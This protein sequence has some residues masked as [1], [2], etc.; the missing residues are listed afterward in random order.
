MKGRRKGSIT[1]FLAIALPVILVLGFKLYDYL[2]LRQ[3]EG[4]ALKITYAV[5]EAELGRY[6][7]YFRDNYYVF[8]CF[9]SNQ[10][11]QFVLDYL[12]LNK[13]RGEDFKATGTYKSLS[14]PVN[15]RKAVLNAAPVF[16]S[17]NIIQ[18][19]KEK[20]GHIKTNQRIKA[21]LDEYEII[22]EKITEQIKLPKAFKKFKNN[23]K[24]SKIKDIIIKSQNQLKEMEESF[25]PLI[26]E[27]GSIL[28]SEGFP[29]DL[30]ESKTESLEASKTEFERIQKNSKEYLNALDYAVSFALE[31]E[32][33]IELE[34]EALEHAKDQIIREEIEQRI[35][36][37]EEDL[38]KAYEEVKKRAKDQNEAPNKSGLSSV[39]RRFDQAKKL[40]SNWFTG[41]LGEN[42][43]INLYSQDFE[44]VDYNV[45]SSLIEKLVINEWCCG[46]F[47]SYDKNCPRK[48]N[49]PGADSQSRIKGEIEYLISGKTSEN[50]SLNTVKLKISAMRYI[51]NIITLMQSKNIRAEIDLITIAIPA[52]FNYIASGICYVVLTGAESYIDTIALL[53]GDGIDFIKKP[54]DWKLSVQGLLSGAFESS[55]QIAETQNSDDSKL[56]Y[57]DYLRLMLAMQREKT[58]IRRAMNIINSDL[59]KIGN[60]AEL[61]DF[62]VGHEIEL[63]WTN[64][65]PFSSRKSEIKFVNTYDTK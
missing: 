1:V 23:Q 31:L 42:G 44:N 50:S 51:P 2:V 35:L 41:F 5:S 28:K 60:G 4:K 56:Y 62:S 27:A 38:E 65:S 32:R 11:A 59:I 37:L 29:A 33:E 6:N 63:S 52:P 15:F 64:I 30:K 20:L 25:S 47:N 46:V 24:M 8:A 7:K 13:I 26:K 57:L 14:D 18:W 45:D 54:S 17:D 53:R 58:I 55:L 21:F 49:A 10:T 39:K 12:H 34:Y 19:I 9:D 36:G 48:F 40:I 43:S 22:E 3:N 61:S 16:L